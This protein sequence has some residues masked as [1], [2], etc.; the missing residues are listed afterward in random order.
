M[1]LPV[2]LQTV[3]A[4]TGYGVQFAQD[5]AGAVLAALPLVVVFL[6]FQRQISTSAAASTRASTSP[7]T[8][9]PTSTACARMCLRWCASWG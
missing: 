2:G 1:T 4:G 9:R 7:A 6:F 3:K 8:P 5:M